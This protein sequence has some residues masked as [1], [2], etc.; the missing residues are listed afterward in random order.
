MPVELAETIEHA[1]GDTAVP[2]AADVAIQP[3][4]TTVA[5]AADEVAWAATTPESESIALAPAL[6][7]A[8]R[9]PA[10][11]GPPTEGGPANRRGESM[12]ARK[13]VETVADE[14]AADDGVGAKAGAAAA[15][16]CCERIA[17]SGQELGI[18]VV[19]LGDS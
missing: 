4:P 10:G 12:K 16:E 18:E 19:T 17:A 3:A 14:H 5:E 13:D 6:V 7:P 1:A 2:D 9:P 11:L 15:D 8:G